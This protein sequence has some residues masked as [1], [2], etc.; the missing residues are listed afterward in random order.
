MN[1]FKNYLPKDL[2][3]LYKK[4]FNDDDDHIWEAVFTV[5]E[6]FRTTASFTDKH[7]GYVY[8]QQVNEN[9]TAYFEQ[10]RNRL[11]EMVSRS[12]Y[13]LIN[14]LVANI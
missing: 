6:L 5:L 9:I 2:Y 11:L 13:T 14:Y 12:E 3:E 1:T 10:M 4:T 8:N 7:F